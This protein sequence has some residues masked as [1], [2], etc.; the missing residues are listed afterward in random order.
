MTVAGNRANPETP[1]SVSF[2]EFGALP[3]QA[4]LAAVVQQRPAGS[5]IRDDGSRAGEAL[6]S[7]CDADERELRKALSRDA[8]A[9]THYFSVHEIIRSGG[10]RFDDRTMRTE[11]FPSLLQARP[12]KGPLPSGAQ[13]A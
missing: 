7:V 12:K 13:P 10:F 4:L 3:A 5:H 9:D 8:G 6:R 11:V 2:A 1:R